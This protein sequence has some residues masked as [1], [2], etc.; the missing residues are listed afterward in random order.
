[1]KSR[2]KTEPAI[3]PVTLAEARS[4]CRVITQGS[5]ATS[6][7]DDDLT[8]YIKAARELAESRTKRALITQTWTAYLD[9]FPWDG[10]P[11]ALPFPRLQSVTSLKYYD[12]EGTLQ[13]L[14]TSAYQVDAI[15]EPGSIS[16][17]P[18]QVWPVTQFQRTNAVEI[19]FVAGYGSTMAS[20]P[21]SLRAWILAAVDFMFE[22]RSTTEITP[23][24]T[25]EVPLDFCE[26]LLITHKMYGRIG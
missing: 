14:P 2:I 15:D 7:D 13:T 16:L 9:G 6:E 11:I 24:L 20:V 4:Q 5:P 8:R 25:T 17:A 3:E 26:D 21:E 23:G 18:S 22:N 10:C 12:G 1:M 19:E